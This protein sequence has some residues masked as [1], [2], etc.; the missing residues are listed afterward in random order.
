[1]RVRAVRD[2]SQ[3]SDA[4]FFV[5]VAQGLSLVLNNAVKLHDGATLI[6]QT[7]GSNACRV[8]DAVA[9]EEAAKFL[10]LIDAVRCPRQPGERF[11]R[12]L[13]RFSDHL[14]KGLYSDACGWRPSTLGQ[15]QE[16]I[17]GCR[18]E[19][20]LDGPNDLDWIFR[21][22]VIQRR[23]GAL[24]VDYV[25]TD[26]GHDWT[27]P[28]EYEGFLTPTYE[29]MSLKMARH[30]S[31]V[32]L[33]T[34]AGLSV[35]ASVW[36]TSA[37]NARTRWSDIRTLNLRTLEALQAEGLLIELSNDMYS[38]IVNDWQFPMYDLDLSMVPVKLDDLR[39]RQRNW[40][41][42]W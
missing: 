11:V 29:P 25:S 9:E 5:S 21:N 10:V 20:Y 12:Q 14:A 23:E 13:G 42:D 7:K 36:R 40:S 3:L 6:A 16:Y 35:V 30:L 34:P 27:N 26:E 39:E 37:L 18:Q 32:G 15:L 41:P 4:E 8:L 31:H 1:M 2:L 24:Y 17:D 19:F 33:S 38:W 22:D 28:G